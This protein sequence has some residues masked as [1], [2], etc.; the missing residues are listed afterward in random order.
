MTAFHKTSVVHPRTGQ[1]IGKAGAR[2]ASANPTL[3]IMDST[4]TLLSVSRHGSVFVAQ[5]ETD[6]RAL[7]RSEA[8]S[9]EGANNG[10]EFMA[11]A[12]WPGRRLS[13]VFLLDNVV[14]LAERH[15]AIEVVPFKVGQTVYSSLYNYP[16]GR[17]SAR[18]KVVSIR[19]GSPYPVEVGELEGDVPG[20]TAL[21]KV[22]ELRAETAEEVALRLL[23]AD[24][25]NY[26]RNK[27][28]L[29]RDLRQ[30]M[31]PNQPGL[32]DAK[33][34]VDDLVGMPASLL[35]E[36]QRTLRK[37][38]R[39]R[40]LAPCDSVEMAPSA[41]ALVGDEGEVTRQYGTRYVVVPDSAPH[42]DLSYSR[43]RLKF[44]RRPLTSADVTIED[45][46]GA[47]QRARI[48]R[49][50]TTDR[51][52]VAITV[53]D[54]VEVVE[55]NAA[56]RYP[57][58]HRGIVRK[59]NRRGAPDVEPLVAVDGIPDIFARRLRKVEQAEPALTEEAILAAVRRG[60]I[61]PLQLRSVFLAARAEGVR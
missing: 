35:P 2:L 53:G 50:P 32:R 11:V 15:G 4:V 54:T 37:G 22:S 40:I 25:M 57:I 47:P 18:G 26:Y 59:I 17:P 45:V 28:R 13:D 12:I 29:I 42:M 56:G 39:V 9:A 51:Y 19:R 33:E 41:L 30:E 49:R 27:V 8:L 10:P 44:L 34:V 5:T 24:P 20:M 61:K 55:T 7:L 38:D 48:V 14:E 1:L 21:F 23:R 58:G 16:T 52:G 6:K 31:A 43:D 46:I 3:P 60:D 36:S